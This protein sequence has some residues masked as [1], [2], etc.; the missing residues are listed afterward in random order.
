ME[1]KNM[2]PAA[3]IEAEAPSR[4][5]M[6]MDNYERAY[7]SGNDFAAELYAL[8][9]A[10]ATSVVKKCLD[11]QRKA[12]VTREEVSNSGHNPALSAVR[13]DIKAD[14]ALYENTVAAHAAAY[15]WK[16]DNDGYVV[17]EVVDKAAEKAATDLQGESFG[18]GID[19]VHAAA[20]ALLEIAATHA[21]QPGWMEKPYTAR[22]IARKVYVKLDDTAAWTEEETSPI[23][24]V[25]RTV[26]REVQNSRAMQTDPRN[27]YLYIEDVAADPESDALETIYRRLGKWADLGGYTCDMNGQPKYDSVYTAD[28][29]T[30]MDYKDIIER[31]A[32]TDRQSTIVRMRMQGYGYRA[33]ATYLGVNPR[34]VYN[35]MEKV[36]AK[37]EKI[38][39]TPDM[40][41][42]MNR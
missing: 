28:M 5:E 21:G 22:R 1:N 23:R 19:L 16:F 27:G 34:A 38:G 17:S 4:F 20:V 40:W 7:A 13:R 11:P 33:I 8:A 25:Y 2:N 35:A 3:K 14:T 24:E 6:L 41:E 10:C 37:C 15:D 9:E 26:R 18:D 29:Q 30:A 36:Q 32:L 42:E 12:A 39:F 31:L